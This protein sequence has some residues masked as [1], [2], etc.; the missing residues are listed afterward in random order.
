M[1]GPKSARV[2]AWLHEPTRPLPG[3]ASQSFPRLEVYSTYRRLGKSEV[4]GYSRKK[5]YCAAGGLIFKL[6][7]LREL[8]PAGDWRA[9]DETPR[10]GG[11]SL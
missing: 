1:A 3:G 9:I 4:V 2:A 10:Y 11:A 8:R 7:E 5:G 6:W